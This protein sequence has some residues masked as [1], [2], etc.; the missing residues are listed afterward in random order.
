SSSS[1]RTVRVRVR[2]RRRSNAR[3]RGVPVGPR[4]RL[5]RRAR[6]PVRMEKTVVALRP[7]PRAPGGAPTGR[8]HPLGCLGIGAGVALELALV[9]IVGGRAGPL[10]AFVFFAVVG[11]TLML[12]V[13]ITVWMGMAALRGQLR[14]LPLLGRWSKQIADQQYG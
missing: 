2:G 5:A 7:L 9:A 3:R 6:R 1:R 14:A 8:A 11:V 10:A 12:P 4:R 13:M